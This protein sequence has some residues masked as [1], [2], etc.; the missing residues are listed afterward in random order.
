MVVQA[1]VSAG[2]VLFSVA[3]MVVFY[4]SCRCKAEAFDLELLAAAVGTSPSTDSMDDF[5][6][7]LFD[8]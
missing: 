1:A 6:G 3:A 5:E 7:N 2:L 4:F 8:E